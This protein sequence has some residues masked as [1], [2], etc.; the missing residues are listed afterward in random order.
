FAHESVAVN[1]TTVVWP[2]GHAEGKSGG[3][4]FVMGAALHTSLDVAERSHDCTSGSETGTP[5]GA[6]HS[7]VSGGGAVRVGGVVSTTVSTDEAWP[8]FAQL[9]VA[10]NATVVG[11]PPGRQP[12][13]KSGGALFES[14]APSQTST[15]VADASHTA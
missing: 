14:E 1:V 8:A 15:A 9:S 11:A 6:V 2:G 5:P 10:V 7:S 12:E 4:S 13:G 3:A